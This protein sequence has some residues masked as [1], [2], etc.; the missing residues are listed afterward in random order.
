MRNAF[1]IKEFCEAYGFSKPTFYRMA[2][3]GEAPQVLRVGERRVLIPL[4]A[5]EAWE[6][7]R[8]TSHRVA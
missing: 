3:R 8:L 4:A 6:K 2:A 1:S 5:V 7:S